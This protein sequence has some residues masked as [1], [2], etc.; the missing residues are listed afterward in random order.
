MRIFR[1]HT[2]LPEDARGAVVALG[3][4]DGIHLGHQAILAEAASIARDAGARLSVLTFEPHPR[5]MFQPGTPAYRL[6]PFR[7][8]ARQLAELGVEDLF[9]LH[10]DAALAALEAEAFVEGVLARGLGAR[11]VVVGY[12]FTF[13]HRRQG[14][15][16]RLQALGGAH[17]F[18]VTSLEPVENADGVTYSSTMIRDFLMRGEPARA[19]ALLGRFWEIEGRVEHGDE[20]GRTIGFPTA[21]V[22]IGEY[23]VPALGVYAVRA[24]VDEGTETV[25]RDGAAN[26]GRRPT[27]DGQSLT[28]EA[29]LFDFAGDLYGRHLRVALV[30]RLRPEKKFDG[31]DALKAQ[32]ARDCADAR[33][34]LAVAPQRPAAD[35]RAAD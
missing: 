20:R 6:T 21:N 12:N 9:V 8:K 10:F 33:R 24:G 3:N 1:H 18:G 22:A 11:H 28:L 16:E 17:G 34:I 31:L 2:D 30:E 15:V 4:F 7:I 19:S 25:W 5:Q 26:L 23:I 27:V 14:N 13:G 29:H 32:I 35:T